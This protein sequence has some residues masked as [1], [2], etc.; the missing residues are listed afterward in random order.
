MKRAL[1]TILALGLCTIASA[2]EKPAS[3]A[4]PKP[5][6]TTTAA[7][8]SAQ[9]DSPLVAAA[10]RANRKGRKPANVIT[11]E[12]LNK[13]GAGAHITTTQTQQPFVAP[14]PVPALR[15]TPEMIHAENVRQ[16]QKRLAAEAETR[17]K[18]DAARA[19]TS[20]AAAAA[21]EEGLYDDTDVDPGEA[22][23]TQSEANQ[24]KPPQR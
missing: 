10:K 4:D 20:A 2:D 3:S 23:K 13:S 1:A 21:S 6:T 8:P 16:E 12:T 9:A 17:K 7:P 11:N 15:P 19:K 14:K 18:A 22:E 24:Q 5:A